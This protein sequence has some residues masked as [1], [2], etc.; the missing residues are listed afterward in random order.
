MCIALIGVKDHGYFHTALFGFVSNNPVKFA[1]F[2]SLVLCSH[3][4]IVKLAKG[5]AV[6]RL[7]VKVRDQ[8]STLTLSPLT[9]SK[10]QGY[11]FWLFGL[12]LFIQQTSCSG[13][14]TKPS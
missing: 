14:Q 8:V 3:Y 11:L 5:A 13:V 12:Y 7:Y 6:I 2:P 10:Y 4:I 1:Y 9:G